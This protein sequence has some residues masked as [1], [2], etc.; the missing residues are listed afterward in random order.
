MDANSALSLSNLCRSAIS[1][2]SLIKN[3]EVT[4]ESIPFITYEKITPNLHTH[5]THIH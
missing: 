4:F 3:T 5:T 1:E 2:L